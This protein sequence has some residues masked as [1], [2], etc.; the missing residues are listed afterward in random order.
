MIYYRYIPYYVAPQ[1]VAPYP[2]YWYYCPSAEAYYPY[3]I[4]CSDA[5]VTVP[6]G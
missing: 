5:W 3:V 2:T 6:A 4:Y 1:Y